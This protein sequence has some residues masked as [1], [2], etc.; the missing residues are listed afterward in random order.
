MKELLVITA[1]L[2]MAQV[3]YSQESNTLTQDRFEAEADALVLARDTKKITE[4]QY[5]QSSAKLIKKFM[6]EQ[7]ELHTLADYRIFIATKLEKKKISREEFDYLISERVNEYRA[8]IK[9]VEDQAKAEEEY[10]QIRQRIAERDRLS[11][12]EAYRAQMA[13]TEAETARQQQSI[14]IAT[15]LQGIGNAFRNAAP[16]APVTCSSVPVGAS[17]STTCY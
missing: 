5:A 15:L 13:E 10:Q 17:L 16:R 6:P 4:L 1:L 8:K 3:G 7:Y 9:K 2:F 12:E 14:G 11:R